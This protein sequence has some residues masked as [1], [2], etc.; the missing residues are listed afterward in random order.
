MLNVISVDVEEYFHATNISSVIG[1]P[2]KHHLASRLEQSIEKVLNIFSRLQVRGTFFILGL[3]AQRFPELIKKIAAEGHEVASHGYG[4][5]LAYNLAPAQFLEDVYRTRLMLED[6]I[7]KPVYGYRA[8]NFSIKE[9]N[10]WAYDKLIEAGYRYD[11]SCYPIWHPR[12]AN[13][14]RSRKPELIKRESGCLFE[15]PLAVGKLNVFGRELRLPLAGGA[16]WRLFPLPYLRWGLRRMQEEEPGWFTCYVHPW[17]FDPG[18]PVFAELSFLTKLR[19]YGRM[20]SFERKFER[21]LQSFEFGP[22]CEAGKQSFGGKFLDQ[23]PFSD[24]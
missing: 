9:G 1:P 22:L 6:M 5:E 12:Y 15:F 10:E 16:Y 2:S 18:Q 20:K 17:E 4:H 24:D 7:G 21:L 3:V 11:S 8:P 19:H 13:Q 14:R 23:S